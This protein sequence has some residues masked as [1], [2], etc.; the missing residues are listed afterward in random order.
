[1]SQRAKQFLDRIFQEEGPEEEEL[2]STDSDGISLNDKS[3]KN[4]VDVNFHD[5][6]R[7]PEDQQI[8]ENVCVNPKK[9]I[10]M[11]HWKT[12]HMAQCVAEFD[13][14]QEEAEFPLTVG[15]FW[16]ERDYE[17]KYGIKFSAFYK[18]ARLDKSKRI[19]PG[20]KPGPG[21]AHDRWAL[22][23][24]DE[25]ADDSVVMGI[26]FEAV[27][28]RGGSF[29]TR[30][31]VLHLKSECCLLRSWL[32]M[33]GFG[34]HDICDHLRN[35]VET[36][37]TNHSQAVSRELECMTPIQRCTS[38]LDLE[39]LQHEVEDTTLGHSTSSKRNNSNK[40]GNSKSD[41][42]NDEYSSD[43]SSSQ[44]SDQ[45]DADMHTVDDL[46]RAQHE[47]R[48]LLLLVNQLLWWLIYFCF[49]GSDL[50]EELSNFAI[51]LENDFSMYSALEKSKCLEQLEQKSED[52]INNYLSGV[53]EVPVVD[54]KELFSPRSWDGDYHMGWGV[55]HSL[56][57]FY[58]GFPS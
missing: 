17:R 20:S 47:I 30:F 52:F 6:K 14:H 1:M 15:P 48:H 58:N 34:E 51:D 56:D 26:L 46:R 19:K 2:E 12:P 39:K 32:S 42:D 8:L 44:E 16:K 45:T 33:Y 25:G 35:F 43:S 5:R 7:A 50:H 28:I 54:V 11:C 18:Y 29:L 23:T 55:Y 13:K 37:E 27:N 49:L 22:T 4:S 31:E 53:V 9:R 24:N 38:F 36:L 10:R 21:K 3:S 57:A 41:C 40:V